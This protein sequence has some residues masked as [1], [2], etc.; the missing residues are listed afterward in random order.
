MICAT[1]YAKDLRVDGRARLQLS[2]SIHKIFRLPDF[3]EVG[4]GILQHI[5]EHC[6]CRQIL[7]VLF[8][9]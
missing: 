5:G 9:H 2:E 4:S 8:I 3:N 1:E 7:A 6:S